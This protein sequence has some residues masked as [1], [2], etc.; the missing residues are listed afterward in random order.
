M[1]MNIQLNMC[2]NELLSYSSGTS[3]LWMQGTLLLFYRSLIHYIFSNVLLHFLDWIT[4]IVLSSSLP[5]PLSSPFCHW[6]HP[7]NF[8]ILI[9][10]FF[11]SICIS[12]W[13]FFI[14]SISFTET[15]FFICFKSIYHYL[16]EP[17]YSS[18]FTV[19][20]WQHLW[21]FAVSVFWFSFPC[22]ILVGFCVTCYTGLLPEHFK[23][24]EMRLLVLLEFY[25][26]SC[27]LLAGNQPG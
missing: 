6:F 27:F 20:V 23:Y 5:T 2:Y 10:V 19:F 22:K 15:Y 8:F 7:M 9:T 21:P 16:L 12:T 18:S 25:E 26:E 24:F 4:S 1:H 11:S 14:A 3:M 13:F 17:V